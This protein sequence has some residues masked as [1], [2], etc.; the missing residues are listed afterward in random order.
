MPS[1]PKKTASKP[2]AAD[3]E[4]VPAS[5]STP[6]PT[7]APV[8]TPEPSKTDVETPPPAPKKAAAPRKPKAETKTVDVKDDKSDEKDG[9]ETSTETATL[10][11][12]AVA[13]LVEKITS[14]AALIKDIQVSIKPVVKEHDKLRKIVEKIQ[15]K[16]ENA[17]KSPSGFAKPN[18]ISNE[19]CEFI[20]VPP[21]TEKSRTEITRYINAY[22]KEHNLNKP[23]NRRIILPD[24]KLKKI[25]KTN[26][27]EEVTFFILQ[28]L[29]SHHFPS[30]KNGVVSPAVVA[31]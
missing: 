14:L 22:V 9:D 6:T 28:R 26:N 30:T 1:Q 8:V 3:N 11:D 17:R 23:T 29:I 13:L 15:K 12:N 25:L 5:V 18:K 20:G 4:I 24:E 7:P 19:L 31:T 2:K 10:N 21:G 27:D 16:R